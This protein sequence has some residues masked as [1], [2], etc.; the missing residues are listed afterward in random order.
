M[1]TNIEIEDDLMDEVMRAGGFKTKREAVHAALTMLRDVKRQG[2]IRELRG[3]G[4][5]WDDDDAPS[6][7]LDAA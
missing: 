4:W 7:D 3:I 1:R 6:D 5:G 2:S